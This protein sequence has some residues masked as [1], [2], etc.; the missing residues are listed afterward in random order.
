MPQRLIE[1]TLAAE[2]ADPALGRTDRPLGRPASERYR[3]AMPTRSELVE[4]S[5]RKV[6]V[7]NPDKVMFAGPGYTKRDLVAYYLVVADGALRGA[8]GRPMALKRYVNGADR[9][10]FFQKRAPE[11]RPDWIRT[12]EISFPSGRTADEVV[13]DDAAGLAWVA[14]LGCLDLNPHAVRADDLD[15]PDE[16]RVD[17]D[18]V[19]GVPWNDMRH[20][21][22]V[23]RDVL[24]DHGLTGWPKTSGSR[25]IHVNVR[26]ERRWSFD[27]VRRAALALAREVERRAPE[28]ASSKWWKEERHGV[29]I[30]YNQNAKDRTVASAYSVRPVPDARVSAPVTW[31]ELPLC[32]LGDFTLATVPAR[33]GKIGDPAAGIDDAVGSLDA[34]LELS[35]RQA[36]AGQGDAPWPPNYA[37]APGE[38]PRVAPSRAR[39]A[40][41]DDDASGEPKPPKPPTSR[42][43]SP[44]GRRAS[45]KPLVEIA[46]AATKEEA[47]AAF[48]RWKAR[49]EA[50]VAQLQP[51]DILVDSMRGRFTLWYRIRVNL[52]H[53][54]EAERP[55]QEPLDADYDPWAEVRQSR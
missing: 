20:V 14:N 34:L 23:V 6:T 16:L 49:H 35:A 13:V 5:G 41:T 52:E 30:D 9:E 3:S 28:I 37:K 21:A 24:A 18:P 32:E 40:T 10:F 42:T 43:P 48:E 54:P 4:A 47:L 2:A 50:I 31:D 39:R 8:G 44:T 33:F 46:R 51:A 27:E 53:V 55:P 45:T 29:F 26:V 19:P 1:R 17:L 15:H 12:V 25:G 11:S 22:L 7:S 36:K 38:P